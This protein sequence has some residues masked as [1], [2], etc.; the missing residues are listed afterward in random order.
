MPVEIRIALLIALFVAG[1]VAR[2]RGWLKPPQAGAMLRLVI[3]VGLPALFIADVSRIPLRAD[4]IALPASSLAIMLATLAASLLVGRGMRL[5]RPEQG[6]LILCGV[7]INNG[8]LFPFVIAAWGQAGFAELALFDLGH[9]IGQSTFVYMLAAWYGGHGASAAAILR[10][11]LT[12]PP[13]WALLAALAINGS[14]VQLPGWVVVPLRT[15]GQAILLLVIVALGVLFDARLIR[16]G[17]VLAALAL[18]IVL[19]LALGLALAW[20]FEL[21]GLT[22]AVLILGAAA[23]IGFSA[24]VFADREGLHRDLAASAASISV[25]LG[26]VYVPLALWLLPR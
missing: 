23:P 18:R 11:A 21:E 26:L 9:I 22:R 4:L 7:S 8:F 19:G 5:P 16:D 25:L 14:D 6:A 1:L 20:A 2:R 3:T 17:R 10:R 13:L 24:V 12:F 15:L